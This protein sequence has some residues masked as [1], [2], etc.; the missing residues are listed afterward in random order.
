G[1]GDRLGHR[2]MGSGGQVQHLQLVLGGEV[3]QQDVEDELVELGFR[4]R[5]GS[6]ELD[7]VL[8]GEHEERRTNLIVVAANRTR[9]LLHGFE[10]CRLRLRRS[11]VDFVGQQNVGENRSGYKGPSPPSRRR[12]L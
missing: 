4:Q 10:Q 5:I 12:V 3:I 11:A 1:R 8:R 2:L 9:K 6:F 7:G